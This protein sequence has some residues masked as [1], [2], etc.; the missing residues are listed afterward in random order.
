MARFRTAALPV[1]AV[2]AFAVGGCTSG[3]QTTADA[4]TTTPAV[5]NP[6]LVTMPLS[7]ELDHLHGLHVDADGTVLAGTHSGLLAL[8][9][10][11][12]TTRV[13]L[14]EDDLMG[15]SGVPGTDTLYSSGHPGPSSDAPNPL[16]LARSTDGGV[17]WESRSLVGEVDFHALASDGAILVGFDT[18]SGIR[19]SADDG[20]TWT[21]GAA[22]GASAVAVNDIGIWAA[23]QGGLLLSTDGAATF[24]PAPGAPPVGLVSAGRDGGLWGMDDDGNAWRSRDGLSWEEFTRVG[25]VEALTAVDYD[26]AYAATA[27]ELHTL[28]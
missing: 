14:S 3:T 18:S 25:E 6:R 19:V 5:V 22:I 4:E 21:P 16:G 10:S 28:R 8:A 11:G 27:Q 24:T 20:A 12:N 15:L 9:P 2:A 1:I 17:T 26:T 7:P 23:T 13:G